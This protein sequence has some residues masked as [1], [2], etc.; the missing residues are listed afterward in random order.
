MTSNDDDVRSVLSTLVRDEPPL[1]TGSADIERRGARR[2]YRRRM[3]F[4]AAALLPALAGGVAFAAWPGSTVAGIGPS[5]ASRQETGTGL[6]SG[7]QLAPGFPVGSA[8]DAVSG[9]LPAGVTVGEL[10]TDIGWREGGTLSV[11][12]AD[13]SALLVT[14]SGGACSVQAAT[15]TGPQGTVVADAV[16]AAWQAAGSPPI[17]PAGPP[18][19]PGTEHPELAAQ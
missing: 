9:A 4:G 6:E 11:P 2:V 19:A 17:L 10:P 5:V 8:V 18:E 1:P 12:L 3:A 13:G 7:T 15:L 14:V 16:C